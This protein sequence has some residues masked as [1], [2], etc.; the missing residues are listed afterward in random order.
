[1]HES[2]YVKAQCKLGHAP[3]LG[4]QEPKFVLLFDIGACAYLD[5]YYRAAVGTMNTAIERACELFVQVVSETRGTPVGAFD[6]FWAGVKNRSEAQIGAFLLAYLYEHG[7]ACGFFAKEI[8]VHGKR[9]SITS[10]RNRVVHQGYIPSQAEAYAF[11]ESAH[12]WLTELSVTLQAAH[13]ESVRR[14]QEE[15]W[16]LQLEAAEK[17]CEKITA[18]MSGGTIIEW[19]GGV[20]HMRCSTFSE[21]LLDLSDH[22]IWQTGLVDF[23]PPGVERPQSHRDRLLRRMTAFS[24]GP[25]KRDGTAT[26]SRLN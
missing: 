6:R 24:P 26:Q 11:G 18:W 23:L 4:V 7:I 2:G 10:F 1:M 20:E 15:Y 13:P 21:G 22:R 3:V 8:S 5:G 25:R 14:I 17:Q 12:H 9:A 19:A 16:A